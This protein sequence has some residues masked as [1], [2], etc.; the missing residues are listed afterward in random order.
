MFAV[1][2]LV[3]RVMRTHMRCEIEIPVGAYS[4]HNVV[5]CGSPATYIDAELEIPVC[6]RCRWLP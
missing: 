1:D 5:V 4:D 3:T 6:D 2:E